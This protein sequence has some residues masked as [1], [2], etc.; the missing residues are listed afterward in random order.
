M[1]KVIHFSKTML[2]GAPIRLVKAL[3]KYSNYNVRLIDLNKC[4]MYDQDLVWNK[5]H[6]DIMYDN[7]KKKMYQL[8][9]DADIIHLHNYIDL[10]SNEFA[11]IS[12][13]D[14]LKN[15]KK[16]IRHFHT[17]PSTLAEVNKIPLSKILDNS[18]PSL[19]IAQFQERY[20]LNSMVVPNISGMNDMILNPSPAENKWDIFYSPS[21]ESSGWSTRWDTKGSIETKEILRNLKRKLKCSVL[22]TSNRPL[23]VVLAEKAKST[24]VIDELITGSYHLSSLEGIA[25][26]KTTLAF[27]DDRTQ[28]VL[29]QI[30]G[31]SVC[32]F[33]NVRLENAEELIRYLLTHP[34]QIKEIG[35]ASR[36]WFDNYW[37]NEKMIKHFVD[38][39]DK[40]MEDPSL[41]CRQQ[42]LRLDDVSTKFFAVTLPDLVYTSR[43]TNYI[44]TIALMK[45]IKNSFYSN[46]R[47]IVLRTFPKKVI[48]Q[49]RKMKR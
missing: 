1:I 33:I 41:I 40:L 12:F 26:G 49:I 16:I 47:K 18:I 4:S 13:R 24:I 29:R 15:G 14:L 42:S 32:P 38:V 19:V 11:P 17:N 10:D 7:S 30:S 35:L 9:Q 22:Y 34:D 21:S 5:Y 31:S 2:A 8:A 20:Y 36:N 46:V 27:L 44:R 23:K 45:V 39:Y 25:L 37:T 43:R 3:N 6:Q 28:Y 48:K